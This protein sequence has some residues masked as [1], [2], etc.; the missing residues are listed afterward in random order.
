M[1]TRIKICGLTRMEDAQRAAD[2]GA[3]ALGFNFYRLSPRYIEPAAARAIIRRLPPFVA[4]V[5]VFANETDAGQV[6]SQAREAGATTVQ[7]HGPRFPALDE[8]LAVFTL[9][10]AV[11]VG[12]GFKPGSSAKSNRAPT[13]SMPL[14]QTGSA[15][16]E[17]HSS[18]KPRGKQSNMGRSSWLAG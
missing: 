2:L 11:A 15:A 6:I 1:P 9:V 10:V 16:R 7:V 17:E 3:A 14:I 5:G 18:G 13:C 4:A 8:L 12:E